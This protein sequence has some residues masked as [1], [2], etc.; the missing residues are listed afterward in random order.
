MHR[1]FWEDKW[2]RN[3][4]GFHQTSVNQYLV[5]YWHQVSCAGQEQVLIPLC[6]KSHDMLWL[7][8]KGHRILGVEWSAVACRQFFEEAGLTAQVT[9]GTP[10]SRYRHQDMELW[11][12]DFFDLS[13]GATHDIR[14][15][16]D[17]AALIAL[18]HSLRDRYATHLK[19]L[20]K[21]GSRILLVTLEYP[22]EEMA[23][24]PFCV[25]DE[26]VKRLFADRFS[27]ELIHTQSLGRDD[28]FAK[29]KGLSYLFEKVFL[30]SSAA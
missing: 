4:I 6:G 14:L 27:I 20:L 29:R 7:N 12:G 10:F 5:N 23:G 21:P 17:R 19:T 11:C 30:L 8:Q 28:P 25:T 13:P 24:P 22:Q 9:P 18:P 16:F 15:V 26:E 1:E 3:E 2:T